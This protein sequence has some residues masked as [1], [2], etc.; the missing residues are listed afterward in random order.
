MAIYKTPAADVHQELKKK[1][2]VDG[3]DFVFD[4]ARSHGSRLVDAATGHE[5][6][7]LFSFFA[8]QPVGFNHPGLKDA[9]FRD[10]LLEAALVKPTNSDVYTQGMADFVGAFSRTLPKTPSGADAFPH[11][12]FIEGG[13]L[14]VENTL[15]VGFD[16]K[17]QKNMRRGLPESLGTQV[18]HFNSAFHGRSGYT[19]SLT[20][21]FDPRKTKWFPKFDWPRLVTPSLKFPITDEVLM[22]VERTEALAIEGFKEACRTRR[23]DIACCIIETVQ[24]EGGDNHFRTEF[25]Q[26]LR[27]LCDEEEVFLIFDEVQCGFGLTGKW[28][29]F[30]HHG[31]YPDAFSFGKKAQ[32]CGLAA[33]PR[34]DEVDSVFKVAS[35]INSTW[36]GNL[37]DMVRCT[38]FIEIIERN[39]LLAN[40]TD[41]GL[42]LKAGLE[43]VAAQFPE[44]ISNVRG[45]G[46]M[47]AFDVA[48]TELRNKL[49][50]RLYD[51]G[52][53]ILVCGSRAL[54]F[55]PVLDFSRDDVDLAV[56]KITASIKALL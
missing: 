46:F 53:L 44:L 25:M 16:W 38:R 42:Y 18:I 15:K 1:L 14:A 48:T 29:A 37:V 4:P 31:V 54:R 10:R 8:S 56:E 24:G 41:T 6:L 12:F 47:V 20:N 55:R 45:V 28:W 13:S 52:V 3:F 19:L 33:S 7:D 30:E 27:D 43:R 9:A 22:Q 50:D 35:R 34:V 32:T 49:R 40:A 36:G 26:A 23:H 11:L 39:Q 2:L 21:T 5:F 51:D 17:V